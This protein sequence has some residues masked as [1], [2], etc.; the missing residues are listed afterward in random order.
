MTFT[1]EKQLQ[2]FTHCSLAAILTKI[3]NK[4]VMCACKNYGMLTP[5]YAYK[6]NVI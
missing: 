3:K 5:G 4:L 6:N 1:T 2:C